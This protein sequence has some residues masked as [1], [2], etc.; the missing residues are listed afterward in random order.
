MVSPHSYRDQVLA[1]LDEPLPALSVSRL[2]SNLQWGIPVPTDP[3][4][5]VG[6]KRGGGVAQKK[7]R[8]H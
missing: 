2:R 5:T 1:M 7:T 6:E 3:D 8:K 4:H